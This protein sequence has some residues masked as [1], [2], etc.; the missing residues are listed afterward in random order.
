MRILVAC[1]SSGGHI[2]PALALI[3]SLKPSV[4]QILLVLPQKSRE[5]KISIT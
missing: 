3:D 1:G 5:N 4:D 2:F